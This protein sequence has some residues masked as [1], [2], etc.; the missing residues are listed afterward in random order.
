MTP[1]EI[2]DARLQGVRPRRNNKQGRK[3]TINTT[4][5]M[6]NEDL[7]KWWYP[8]PTTL[9]TSQEKK[10]IVGCI[11]QQLVKLVFGTHFFMWNREIHHQQGGAPM[12]LDSSCP[13]AEQ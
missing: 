13:S 5:T 8:K 2:V 9:L 11:V 10:T 4:S 7:V 6:T 3:S 1:S 12:G